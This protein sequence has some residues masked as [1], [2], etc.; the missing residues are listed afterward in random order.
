M[1]YAGLKDDAQGADL[2]AYLATLHWK[3]R[4]VAAQ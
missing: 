1:I 2:V 4:P 3:R